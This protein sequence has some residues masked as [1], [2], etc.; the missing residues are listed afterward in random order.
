VQ[1]RSYAIESPGLA[2]RLLALSGYFGFVPLLRLLGVRRDDAYLRHH[3]AQALA[4]LLS[5]LPLVLLT[6]V[7]L[8]IDTYLLQHQPLLYELDLATLVERA[9]Y[10]PLQLLGVVWV[11][12]WLAAMGLA[13][14]GSTRRPPLI[15]GDRSPVAQRLAMAWSGLLLLLVPLLATLALVSRQITCTSGGPAPVYFLFDPRGYEAL[16]TWGPR[17]LF[18]RVARQANARWGEG[19]AVVAPANAGNL[20][21][22]LEHGRFVVLLVH[23]GEDGLI[24]SPDWYVFPYFSGTHA[25]PYLELIDR[26]GGDRETLQPGKDLRLLYNSGCRTGDRG[27]DRVWKQ[28][29]APAEVITFNRMSGG[30]EHLWWIWTEAPERVKAMR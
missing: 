26:K 18:Y 16:G 3:Q 21:Q 1:A 11:V 19:S 27:Y 10:L 25:T 7:L 6:L 15:R 24:G 13:L 9:V 14:A 5:F 4:T 20:K 22:A 2:C 17:M 23:G 8:F 29:F 30:L 28:V 12:L